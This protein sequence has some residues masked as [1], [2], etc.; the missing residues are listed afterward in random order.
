[1]EKQSDKQ[2]EE[3]KHAAKQYRD[4]LPGS[5][6]EE[7]LQARGLV[8]PEASQFGLGFVAEPLP[9]HSRYAGML[10]IPYIRRTALGETLVVSLRFRCIID[11]EHR[12]HGKYQTM[13]GDRPRLYN[14]VALQLPGSSIAITEGEVDAIS[15]TLAGV[16]A[17][18]VPG[19]QSWKKFFAEP[20]L[21][22]TDVLVLADGDEP[23][24]EFARAVAQQIPAARV[25]P[26]PPGYDV[27]SLVV[28]LGK[29][30]LHRRTN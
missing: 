7:Y 11:H 19:V 12:G 26:M 23:G 3:L 1:M 5:P 14:T 16:P 24:L 22:Y 30:E 13:P 17:V 29:E 2:R 9:G 21:G 4:A 25:V 10:A 27:N 28:K 6:A 18:G 8:G 20:F 15:A